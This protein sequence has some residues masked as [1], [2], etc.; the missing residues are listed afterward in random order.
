MLARGMIMTMTGKI[1]G[2]MAGWLA[3]NVNMLLTTATTTSTVWAVRSEKERVEN[4]RQ[5]K[6]LKSV[7]KADRESGTRRLP[8][9]QTPGGRTQRERLL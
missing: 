7:R 6:V 4:K 1:A 2:W 5:E 9:G 8:P 3:A